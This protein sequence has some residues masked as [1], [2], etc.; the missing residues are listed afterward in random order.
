MSRLFDGHKTRIIFLLAPFDAGTLYFHRETTPPGMSAGGPNDV[1]VMENNRMRTFY[2]K[3][4][5]TATAANI[6]VQYDPAFYQSVDNLLGQNG[7]IQVRFPD[8][9]VITFWG[10]LDEWRP[11]AAKEGEPPTAEIKIEVSNV[12]DFGLEIK[13][14]YTPPPGA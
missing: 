1:T 12:D 11:N 2:P 13:P 9:S 3:K 6:S 5:I 7:Q 8:D 4:L 10:W 14:I